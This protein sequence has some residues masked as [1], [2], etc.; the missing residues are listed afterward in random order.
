[1]HG[2]RISQHLF[3]FEGEVGKMT[4]QS[5][6]KKVQID[7]RNAYVKI[8]H[9]FGGTTSKSKLTVDREF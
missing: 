4:S 2:S 1:M 3:L 7:Q 6:R 8:L 9:N 5:L